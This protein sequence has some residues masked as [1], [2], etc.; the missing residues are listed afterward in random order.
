MEDCRWREGR[1]TRTMN[2]EAAGV[3]AHLFT[4]LCSTTTGK[5]CQT[6]SR[7][8]K[9]KWEN[10]WRQR[11][12]GVTVRQRVERNEDRMRFTAS[13]SLQQRNRMVSSVL[14]HLNY[15]ATTVTLVCETQCDTCGPC[16]VCSVCCTGHRWRELSSASAAFLQTAASWEACS[17][18]MFH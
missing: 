9:V 1:A 14:T 10:R 5:E 13:V 4:C 6:E 2:S 8:R 3:F 11:H 12:D 15:G 16:I 18:M 7:C 17:V